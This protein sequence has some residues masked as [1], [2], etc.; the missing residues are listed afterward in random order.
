MP[1]RYCP[2]CHI[3]PLR[4]REVNT[5]GSSECVQLWRSL[6][7]TQK[8]KAM[9]GDMDD[10]EFELRKG[11]LVRRPIPVIPTEKDEDFLKTVFKDP[12]KKEEDK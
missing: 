7:P 12:P 5:C 9:E 2:I 10:S 3:V 4:R 8:V 1:T 6:S 11:N